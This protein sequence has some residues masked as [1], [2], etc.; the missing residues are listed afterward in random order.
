MVLLLSSMMSPPKSEPLPTISVCFFTQICH[1]NPQITYS[2][3]SKQGPVSSSCYANFVT[4]RPATG[5]TDITN[6]AVTTGEDLII[7]TLGNLTAVVL[8][9]T[10]SLA[11]ASLA[12]ATSG[13]QITQTQVDDLE[14]AVNGTVAAFQGLAAAFQVAITSP[15][16]DA[17]TEAAIMTAATA[18][19][20]VLFAFTAAAA[21]FVAT[22]SKLVS[23]N[24]AIS[25]L[26]DAIDALEA[27]V[28][29]VFSGTGI[30]L[31]TL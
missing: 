4:R 23:A 8:D 2:E 16:L 25:G 15:N 14:T 12:V 5:A 26:Q 19:G 28:E 31:P 18:A 30:P 22:I 24:I 29:T 21:S 11:G 7:S 20:A 17:V 13:Q 3:S 10:F 6:G 27:A 9:Q 1:N